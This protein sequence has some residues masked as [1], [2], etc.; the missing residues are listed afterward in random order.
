MERYNPESYKPILNFKLGPSG[1]KIPKLDFSEKHFT[2]EQIFL[3]VTDL[4]NILPNCGAENDDYDSGDIDS[5]FERNKLVSRP[6][7]QAALELNPEENVIESKYFD[8]PAR[9]GT[10]LKVRQEM[11]PVDEVYQLFRYRL[12][13]FDHGQVKYFPVSWKGTSL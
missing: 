12:R 13:N 2:F 11:I 6:E 9:A 1:F 3:I 10:G 7:S 4:R 5:N 8:P